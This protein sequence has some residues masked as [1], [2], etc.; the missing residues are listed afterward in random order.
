V[1]S[2]RLD[3]ARR[4]IEAYNS[5]H[6]EAVVELLDEEIEAVVPDGMA[7][8]GTYYGHQGFRRMTKDWEEAWEEFRV[9][10]ED[11]IEEGD[12]VIAPVMQHARGRGS[13]VET[14]MHAVHLMRF[15]RGLM[16]RWRLCETLDEAERH[17]HD[18]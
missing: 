5:G 7:N 9:D 13:G 8:A 10:I 16:Y 15:R 2:E 14:H 3:I 11:L 12:A 18:P 4:G 1:P 6:F 17:A